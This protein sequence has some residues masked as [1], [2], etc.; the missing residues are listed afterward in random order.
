[1]TRWSSLRGRLWLWLGCLAAV[2]FPLALLKLGARPAAAGD[3]SPVA[4]AIDTRSNMDA[5]AGEAKAAE[6]SDEPLPPALRHSSI[7]PAVVGAIAFVVMAVFLALAPEA[8]AGG[9]LIAF[10][11]WSSIC[12]GSVAAMMI[13]ALTGGR[14]GRRFNVVFMPTAAAIP[15]VAV[16]FVPVLVAPSTFFPWAAGTADVEPDVLAHYLNVPFY[17]GRSLIAFAAS[18]LIAYVLPRLSGSLRTLVAGVGLALYGFGIGIVGLDWVLS[19][20]PPFMSTSFGATLAFVQLA[21]AFAWA[22]IVSAPAEQDAASADLG[23]LLLATLLGITYMNFMAVLIIWY[24]D[25]P[26]QVFW[27]VHRDRWPWTV[28]AGLAFVL[29]SVVPIFALFV[30]WI[31]SNP[32]WLRVVS[33][34]ALAGIALY[35]AYCIAPRFNLLSLAAAAVAAIA[36]GA[37]VLVTMALPWSQAGYRSWSAR[38]ET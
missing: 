4:P 22:L 7:P 26:K 11:F 6:G 24:G 36:M 10:M 16:L 12:G 1:M 33:V 30:G 14:W 2:L 17:I 20:E 9:W 29:G 34:V 37:T 28:V 27:L 15:A 3:E 18:A 35:F 21:C 38:N 8:A 23:G 31:R 13:H 25:V 32:F 19:L 5:E